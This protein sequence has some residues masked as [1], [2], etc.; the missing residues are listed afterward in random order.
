MITVDKNA[1]YPK[2]I[3]T[4]KADKTLCEATELRQKNYLNNI[5]EQAHRAIKRRAERR[6]GKQDRLTQHGRS[7]KG[8]EATNM[9]RKGQVQDVKKRTV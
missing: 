1:A 8:F 5:V 2:T 3:E 7:L 6:Y 4:L 9:T